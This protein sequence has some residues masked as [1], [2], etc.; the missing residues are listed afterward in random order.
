MP[1]DTPREVGRR[2]ATTRRARR[3]TQAELAR[4]AYVSLATVKAIERGVRRPSADALDSIADA[5]GVDPGRLV[6]GA[7]HTSGRIHAAI[8]AISAAIA[9]YDLPGDRP[10]RPLADL[11][12]DV[13]TLVGWRLAAQY[14][15]IA[16][17]APQLLT[18]SLAALHHARGAN[19]PRAAGLLAATA[20]AADAVAF[21]A[22]YT[23][24]SARLIELM[25][26]AAPQSED[27]L[28]ESTAAYVR[29]EVF[30]AARA[31]A[32]GLRALELA[33][34]AGPPLSG[35][36]AAAARGALHMRAAVI[37]GRAGNADAAMLHLDEARALGDLTPEGT[38]GG[39]AFG[40]DSVRAH[41]VS[42]AVSL[43]GDHVRRALKVAEEWTPP[44][45]LPAERQ[46]GFWI[47]LSRAQLWAGRTE[48]AFESL[49]VA[50]HIAPQHTREHPWARD[51]AATLR[52]LRRAD[53]ESL[54]SFAEWI[55]AI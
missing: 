49:K 15:R 41:E 40:P 22:G 35:R 48:D 26:W 21:K 11:A 34:D 36:D 5:L 29:T 50:R 53:A 55:G 45:H 23:D 14:T 3:M 42:V 43:G 10:P 1:T 18:E 44:D 31:H 54:T 4:T 19:R 52:R 39:T 47:E 27:P 38:Y 20:R 25:R 7:G 13:Q 8:P 2:I 37:A 28:V 51:T 33:V 32:Q 24:L 17:L 9:A 12:T 46:S 6:T 16:A 30:F